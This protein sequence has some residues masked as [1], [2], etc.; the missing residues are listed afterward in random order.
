MQPH[1]IVR[2]L[3]YLTFALLM[4]RLHYLCLDIQVEH[5]LCIA[6]VVAADDCRV[7]R[8]VVAVA[9]TH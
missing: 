4:S 9:P 1:C 8:L 6:A 3:A 2:P 5:L 7:A